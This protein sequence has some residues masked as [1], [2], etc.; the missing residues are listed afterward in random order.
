MNGEVNLKKTKILIVSAAIAISSIAPSAFA[1]SVVPIV[2][3]QGTIPESITAS[4]TALS[5]I[6][7]QIGNFKVY[8]TGVNPDARISFVD[9]AKLAQNDDPVTSRAGDRRVYVKTEYAVGALTLVG[10]F[11]GPINNQK[12]IVSVAK[13]HTN[14]ASQTVTVSGSLQVTGSYN[15]NVLGLIKA[16]L[17]VQASGSVS[18][19]YNT[20]D[21]WT[22]PEA[23]SPYNSRSYYGAID[24]DQY[25]ITI[26]Q[27][28]YYDEYLGSSYLGRVA[29]VAGYIYAN[30][31]KKPI[32]IEYSVD[33]NI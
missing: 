6:D 1:E 5:D 24:Y 11:V 13:G 28:D 19:T 32:N 26:T 23:S 22:G 31:T 9:P 25:N 15:Q 16:S 10:N 27:Y 29:Q 12:F 8:D 3:E 21:T 20:T 7:G 33:R 2:A 17:N 30:N 18:K 14:Q 4:I